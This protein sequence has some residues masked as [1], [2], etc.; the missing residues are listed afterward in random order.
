VD[1]YQEPSDRFFAKMLAKA[2]QSFIFETLFARQANDIAVGVE[3]ILG[4]EGRRSIAPI[5]RNVAC[6]HLNYFV[7]ESGQKA[8]TA[9][10]WSQGEATK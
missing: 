6:H 7:S 1:A 3:S 2:G 10:Q 4:I 9:V 5:R 8:L